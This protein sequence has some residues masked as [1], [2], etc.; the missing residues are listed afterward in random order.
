LVSALIGREML[1]DI[2]QKAIASEYRFYSFGD[3][4]VIL[5]ADKKKS[6]ELD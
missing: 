6:I 3:A 2:Y 1:L 5:P 4:M